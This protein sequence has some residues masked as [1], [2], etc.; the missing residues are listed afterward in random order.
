MREKTDAT[1][2]RDHSHSARIYRRLRQYFHHARKLAD[3]HSLVDKV[4]AADL[5]PADRAKLLDAAEVGIWSCKARA[6]KADDWM[7]LL[8]LIP[9]KHLRGKVAS[10]CWWDYGTKV[11]ALRDAMRSYNRFAPDDDS[12]LCDALR[13][14]GYPA[15]LA[16]QRCVVPKTRYLFRN[17]EVAT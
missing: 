10:I 14:I 16:R 17:M 2:P 9:D 1:P 4:Q 3:W 8:A 7:R 12:S 5:A 13:R 11:K 15:K 6:M